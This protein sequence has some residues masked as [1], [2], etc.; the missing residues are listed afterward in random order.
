MPAIALYE[1]L[2]FA[3][4]RDVEVW[5]LEQRVSRQHDVRS[6]PREQ[7]QV[8]IA[9]ERQQR[10]PWQ[11]ADESIAHYEDVEALES[12]RGAVLFKRSGERAS[13]L[14]GVAADEEGARELIEALPAEASA[15][16]LAERAR[17]R[18]LQRRDRLPRW[19]E[20]VDAARDAARARGAT[21][22]VSWISAGS[23]L[24]W[25]S[26]SGSSSSRVRLSK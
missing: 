4:V 10:E 3:T 18:P 2:G 21:Q 26:R 5:T 1:K 25:L 17:G 8:R 15:L 23:S 22:L 13:L 16:A 9:R 6:V 14:Q 12:G 11:R 7:A 24:G 19:H 20:S